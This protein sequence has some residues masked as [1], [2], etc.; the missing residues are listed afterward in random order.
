MSEA[1]VVDS[2]VDQT[3]ARQAVQITDALLERQHHHNRAP[4][5]PCEVAARISEYACVQRVRSRSHSP[6]PSPRLHAAFNREHVSPVHSHHDSSPGPY[7]SFGKVGRRA[8]GSVIEPKNS[9]DSALQRSQLSSQVDDVFQSALKAGALR[10]TATMGAA[11]MHVHH[12]SQR[13]PEQ[14]VSGTLPPK[15]PLTGALPHAYVQHIQ[16]AQHG[17]MHAERATR[18]CMSDVQELT[19][20]SRRDIS[21]YS[22]YSPGAMRFVRPSRLVENS[23]NNARHM[24]RK[25]LNPQVSGLPRLPAVP[26]ME[27]LKHNGGVPLPQNAPLPHNPGDLTSFGSPGVAFASP[28]SHPMSLVPFLTTYVS[29]NKYPTASELTSP[30]ITRFRLKVLA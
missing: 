4:M 16:K 21:A 19:T 26:F 27:R 9:V 6:D 22:M 15:S 11:S 5:K 2:S 14:P 17:S 23:G 25:Q 7:Q 28:T 29:H 8:G 24:A 3:K 13:P 18:R 30:S 1:K 12:A 10:R 20:G